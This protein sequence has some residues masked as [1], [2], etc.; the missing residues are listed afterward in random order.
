MFSYFVSI[1]LSI[2][3]LSIILSSSSVFAHS[4][5]V[6]DTYINSSSIIDQDLDKWFINKIEAEKIPYYSKD[7]ENTVV[8]D[9]TTLYILTKLRDESSSLNHSN[10]IY[11]FDNKHD[12]YINQGDDFI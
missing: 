1:F 12:G 7:I 9:N 3:T 11:I 2:F 6:Y 10:I 4:G 8:Y 5:I